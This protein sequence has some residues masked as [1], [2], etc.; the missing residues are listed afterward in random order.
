MRAQAAMDEFD[1]KTRAARADVYRQMEDNRRAAQ[2]TRAE[3][4][5]ATRGEVERSLADAAIRLQNQ[6]EAAAGQSQVCHHLRQIDWPKSVDG[7]DLDQN[8]ALDEDVHFIAAIDLNLLELN[9]QRLFDL[10]EQPVADQLVH[11]TTL[12]DLFE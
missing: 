5:A 4:V 8:P 9:W 10:D 2:A 6:T 12:V 1:A 3:L 7:F 11:E